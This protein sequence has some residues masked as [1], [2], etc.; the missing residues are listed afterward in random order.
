MTPNFIKS[1]IEKTELVDK[2][3]KSLPS[4]L[5]QSIESDGSIGQQALSGYIG[6]IPNESFKSVLQSNIDKNLQ[7]L[8]DPSKTELNF[9]LSGVMSNIPD[10]V[11]QAALESGE[12]QLK[13]SY[14]YKIPT[15]IRIYRFITNNLFWI[16][17]AGYSFFV[18]LL[19]LIFISA[20][21]WQTK[22]RASSLALLVPGFTIFV[23]FF[24]LRVLPIDLPELNGVPQIIS[25]LA[26]EA[27]NVVKIDIANRYV[28]QAFVL[29]CLAFIL[30][31]ISFLLPKPEIQSPSRSQKTE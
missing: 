11:K 20:D 7:A 15:E 25:T 27:F 16:E 12:I 24:L 8:T 17:V 13:D 9:D 18:C 26:N 6:K 23:P 14:N 30:F 2:L 21:A 3:S 31:M 10:E 1:E 5:A 29:I 22:L 28:L 19:L 4:D